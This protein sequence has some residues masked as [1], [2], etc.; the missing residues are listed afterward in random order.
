MI[1]IDLIACNVTCTLFPAHPTT[2]RPI[3]LKILATD[4]L[5]A[6]CA[7]YARFVALTVVLEA[8]RSAAIAPLLMRARVITSA[9]N[10]R[11]KGKGIAVQAGANGLGA[12]L[13]ILKV[14]VTVHAVAPLTEVPIGKALAIEL[15][16]HG[17]GAV[18]WLV[19]FAI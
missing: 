19:H 9:A 11:P 3:A 18:A 12:I 7:R 8:T 15:E 2:S 4:T 1:V 13:I 16:A 14:V 17:L 5:A 10:L 6:R